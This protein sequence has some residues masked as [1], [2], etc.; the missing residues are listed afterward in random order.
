MRQFAN[1]TNVV[2]EGH[3]RVK[4]YSILLRYLLQALFICFLTD[5]DKCIVQLF[6]NICMLMSSLYDIFHKLC[7]FIL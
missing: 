2:G 1:T 7:W 5:L 6:E 3:V 4:D